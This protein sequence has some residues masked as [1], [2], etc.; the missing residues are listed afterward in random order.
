MAFPL[1]SIIIPTLNS[2]ATLARCLDSIR[3]QDYP[4]DRLEILVCDGGSSDD[5]RSIAQH[6]HA[7]ILENPLQTGEAGKSVGLKNA[8][9]ELIGFIDSDNF[10][11][12]SDWLSRMISIFQSDSQ[13]VLAEPVRFAWDP[14]APSIIRYCAL[15]G[16]NDPLCF[17]TGHFDRWNEAIQNW[18]RLD[19][20]THQEK[21]WFWF[22]GNI[23]RWPTVGA[24]GTFYRRSSLAP[25]ENED[26]F[27][28]I[29]I[30][31]QIGRTNPQ[32]RFAKADLSILHWYCP[33]WPD[34]LRKQ[35]RRMR[36]YRHFQS[37]AQ[38]PRQT[39]Q[40]PI[41]SIAMFIVSTLLIF[42]CLWISWKGYRQKRDS[43]WFLHWP[44]C[45]A[46]LI[47][48]SSQ[49]VLSAI[50]GPMSRQRWQCR[51]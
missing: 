47:I 9:S 2:S 11:T 25:F 32:A 30:P 40:Y 38:R 10:L 15:M 49:F 21:N 23:K 27:F 28:D 16:L 1:V 20:P 31:P 18:T 12:S 43:A 3:N 44:L 14:Q 46:T 42:P 8:T 4:A 37:T 26:Y 41:A 24:N 35:V 19:I 17:Y 48:Y 51:S 22:E 5:T 34:F 13:V 29:D 33:K 39:S 50:L 36:D 6:Y 7:R 45:L